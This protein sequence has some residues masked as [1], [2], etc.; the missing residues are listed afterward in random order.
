MA[1]LLATVGADGLG[2]G[3]CVVAAWEAGGAAPGDREER[4]RGLFRALAERVELLLARRDG[5]RTVVQVR[6]ARFFGVDATRLGDLTVRAASVAG[7][8]GSAVQWVPLDPRGYDR[9]A[10][11][12]LVLADFVTNRLNR[13]LRGGPWDRIATEIRQDTGL[14][15]TSAPAWAQAPLPSIASLGLP[16]QAVHAALAAKD[17]DDAALAA[18]KPPWTGQQARAWVDAVSAARPPVEA[19]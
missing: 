18:T 7:A 5:V 15:A 16:A 19:A 6:A 14:E 4:Y 17:V 8:V 11:P 1:D 12:S 2:G 10:H 3:A 13:T 9:V